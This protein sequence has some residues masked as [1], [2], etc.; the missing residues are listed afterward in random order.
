MRSLYID[1]GCIKSRVWG[2]NLPLLVGST[3]LLEF[4]LAALLLKSH[5]GVPGTICR[6]AP[7]KHTP[8]QP[9]MR[10]VPLN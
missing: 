3:A 6:L 1:A 4:C 2:T 7:A 5:E 10:A 8:L 9:L